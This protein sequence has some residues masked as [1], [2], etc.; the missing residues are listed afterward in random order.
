M[1]LFTTIGRRKIAGHKKSSLSN[2]IRELDLSKVKRVYF[3]LV[4]GNGATC[5]P[6]VNAGDKVKV[7]TRI[8]YR[9]QMSVPLFSSVSGTVEGIEKRLNVINGR[10]VDHLVIVNDFQMTKDSLLETV[11]LDAPREHIVEAIK[12]AGIVGLGGAGFPTWIKYYNVQNI[13]TVLIN[14]VECEPY[15]TT[16]YCMSK[17]FAKE[18]VEGARYLERAAGASNVIISLKVGKEAA[19]DA[20]REAAQEFSDVKVV[21]VPDKYP[22]GWEGTLVYQIFKKRY[23]KLPGEIGVIVNNVTTAISVYNAL[24]KGEVIT[25]RLITVSGNIVNNPGNIYVPVG[26]LASD[27]LAQFDLRTDVEFNLLAGG[28]MTSGA[29][30]DSSF[31]LQASH[32]GLTLLERVKFRTIPCLRCGECTANCPVGLQPVEIMKAFEAR[33]NVRISKLEALRCVDCGLCS[34][35]CPSKIEVAE[36]VKNA[37]VLLRAKPVGK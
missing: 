10:V 9:E 20:L 37:K 23:D 11:S 5:A 7:G 36:F 1:N 33:D 16:D 19:R 24:V 13:H 28:P 30:K 15:L 32:G 22:M 2:E 27:V 4:A 35:V 29:V 18:I 26:T 17:A 14:A 3:P 31:A 12:E 25:K 8:A 21:E 34:Y 6:L